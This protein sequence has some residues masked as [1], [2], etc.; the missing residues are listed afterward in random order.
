MS[1]A[2]T[3]AAAGLGTFSSAGAASTPGLTVTGAAFT[4][5]TSTTN[6]PQLYVNAGTGP[7]TFSAN[8]TQIGINTANAFTGN[9][10][11]GHVNGGA[12]VWSVNYQGNEILAGTLSVTGHV[13][14]E[15][16]TSTGATGTGNLA[17]SAS[18]TFTGTLTAATVAATTLSGA[19]NFSGTP[20]FANAIAL[21]SSTATTQGNCDNS[22]K[23]ATTAY[24]NTECTN[25]ESSGSPLTLTGLTG[26]YYNDTAAA[27]T[28]QL[29]APVAGKQY[30][31]GN[32]KARTSAVTIKS[33]ASVTIYYKG[34]AG[35]TGTGGSL[36]SGGAAGDF[37]CMVGTDTTTYEVTGAGF[38]TWVNN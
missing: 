7:T 2:G 8:G 34:V 11:D 33:L 18:P 17:F 35:T 29:D 26:Y 21:G 37:I 38:G 6:F 15:A 1:L 28:F 36:V 27:Y 12:S 9:L 4:G 14:L 3:F 30:C 23:L 25:I 22:T 24:T 32:R 19:V 5:G 13:T 20:T 10:I 16:V 31:F